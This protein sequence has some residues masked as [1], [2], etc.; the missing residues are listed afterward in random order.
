MARAPTSGTAQAKA[1][2]RAVPE[3]SAP[4]KPRQSKED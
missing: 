2:I 4:P 1:M 3:V